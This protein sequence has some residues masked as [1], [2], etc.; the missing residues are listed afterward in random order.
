MDEQNTEMVD[1]VG[2]FANKVVTSF[3]ARLAGG[4]HHL[5]R[6]FQDLVADHSGTAVEQR[7]GVGTGWRIG[8]AVPNDRHQ[9]CH[10]GSFR[11]HESTCLR[12]EN[13]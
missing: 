8:F 2:R 7:D 3:D 13:A 1:Q 11:I 6:L 5:A 9:L 4:F 10:D 12:D